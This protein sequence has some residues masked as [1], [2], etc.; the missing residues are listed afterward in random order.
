MNRLLLT[1]LLLLAALPARAQTTNVV[2]L[3]TFTNVVRGV[4]NGDTITINGDVRR[5]TNGAIAGT[6]YI[7]STNIVGHAATN[8]WLRLAVYTPSFVDRIFTTNTNSLVIQGKLLSSLT[9]SLSSGIGTVAYSTQTWSTVY[10]IV[11]PN[12]GVPTEAGR[13]NNASQ[14]IALLNDNR[15][16]NVVANGNPALSN[17]F[18][19]TSQQRGSNKVFIAS[20]NQNGSLSNNAVTRALIS[21]NA[22]GGGIWGTS[23]GLPQF[24]IFADVQG[25]IVLVDTNGNAVNWTN[26]Y[27]TAQLLN[28]Q[29][30]LGL[31]PDQSKLIRSSNYWTTQ[32]HWAFTGQSFPFGFDATNPVLRGGISGGMILSNYYIHFYGQVT[33]GQSWLRIGT[34]SSNLA[35]RLTVT[36]NGGLPAL[37]DDDT[38]TAYDPEGGLFGGH[39]LEES[40]LV[41]LLTLVRASGVLSTNWNRN[42]NP[43]NLWQIPNTWSNAQ[44]VFLLAPYFPAGFNATGAVSHAQTSRDFTATGTNTFGGDM[45]FPRFDISTVAAGHN[46]I[47]VKTNVYIRLTGSPGSDWTLGGIT[48]GSIRDGKL[49]IIENRTGY[50][51]TIQNESGTAPTAAERILTLASSGNVTNATLVGDGTMMFVYNGASA[52]WILLKPDVDVSATATNAITTISTN[53]VPVSSAATGLDFT[54]AT[55]Y[56]VGGTV[57]INPG[58]SAGSGEANVN[59]EIS[60]T[61]ATRLG[62]V[63]GKA[64]VTN[65]LRSL[66]GGNGIEITNQGT[67][68]VIAATATAGVE[69][70]ASNGIAIAYVN[71]TNFI[72]VNGDISAGTNLPVIKTMTSSDIAFTFTRNA[73]GTTNA[74]MVVTGGSATNAQPPATILTNLSNL[75]TPGENATLRWQY[76][77]PAWSEAS[78]FYVADYF[79]T[80]FSSYGAIQSGAGGAT[81]G[82]ATMPSSSR[83]NR[84]GFA[85]MRAYGT[86]AVG[87]TH[88][89]RHMYLPFAAFGLFSNNYGFETE[90][91]CENAITNSLLQVGLLTSNTTSNQTAGGVFWEYNPVHSANWIARCYGSSSISQTTTVAVALNTW[92]KLGFRCQG[93]NSVV[94]YTNAVPFWTNS[95]AANMPTASTYMGAILSN[96]ITNAPG[97]G[98]FHSVFLD[99]VKSY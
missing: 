70:T 72:S 9:V 13:T 36:A 48:S 21:S 31:F 94:F 90:L 97:H 98:T 64:G 92:V 23:N 66:S 40:Q 6:A 15:P 68:L 85:L 10:P 89:A 51:V 75:A 20:T 50:S 56:V 65:L 38:L 99:Y 57:F 11:G 81:V 61:N 25:R 86:N 74:A 7:L 4:T 76:G 19:L 43:T 24:Q 71:G 83:E 41:N 26:A 91:V 79:T 44:N 46:V 12:G 63:Y 55:G 62:L 45:S 18:D 30:A 87:G 52:R 16:T 29:T 96:S 14:L 39:A 5:Y 17:L 78:Q 42:I 84:N 34:V 1:L 59:G 28:V 27:S 58:V 60:V 53:G 3:V 33:N 8:T 2:A 32:N 49:I 35:S 93:T 77:G 54:N 95:T 69:L 82:Y 67:N 37:I 73:D 22:P 47:D 80:Q 88:Y